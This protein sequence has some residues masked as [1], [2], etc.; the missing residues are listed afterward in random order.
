MQ[1]NHVFIPYGF[2]WST[3]FTR[4]QGNFA[5]QH[6]MLFAADVTKRFL[7]ERDITPQAFDALSLG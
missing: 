1:F 2:Y 7:R 4:W 6:P 5:Q 3:P